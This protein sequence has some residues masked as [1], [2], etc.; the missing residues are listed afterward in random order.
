[1]RSIYIYDISSLRVNILSRIFLY[2]KVK[3]KVKVR[4][5]VKINSNVKFTLESPWRSRPGIEVQFYAV[6]TSALDGVVGQRHAPAAFLPGKE[7]RFPLYR[8]LFRPASGPV[9]TGAENVAVPSRFEPRSVRSLFRL[10]N[11]K[12]SHYSPGQARRVAGGWG[13]QISKQSAH[14]GGKVVSP[15]HRSPLPSGIIPC[16]HFC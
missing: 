3:V 9:W 2:L 8:R 5:K 12:Q 6:L 10:V 4:I 1:M 14:D 7:A 11:I 13:S 15:T 16:T